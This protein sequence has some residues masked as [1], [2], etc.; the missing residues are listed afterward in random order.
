MARG[1]P[2]S[3]A[4]AKPFVDR[5]NHRQPMI[6]DGIARRMCDRELVRCHR[7]SVSSEPVDHSAG[8]DIDNCGIVQTYDLGGICHHS[9]R[10]I[11]Q[12]AIPPFRLQSLEAPA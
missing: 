10:G 7:Y 9:P 12:A 6:G 8:H 2:G 5:Q 1:L 4:E 11:V 3:P